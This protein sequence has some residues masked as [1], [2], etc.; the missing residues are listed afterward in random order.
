MGS[1]SS[2]FTWNKSNF[3]NF[4]MTPQELINKIDKYK[5]CYENMQDIKYF[6]VKN[7]L[8]IF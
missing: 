5:D 8:I 2:S 4:D 1:V 7:V 6:I 3:V